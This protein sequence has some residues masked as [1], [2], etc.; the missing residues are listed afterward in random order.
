MS[1]TETENSEG[2]KKLRERAEQAAEL[3]AK[4]AVLERK[5]ALREAGVDLDSEL[6]QEL[7]ANP[8]LDIERWKKIATPAQAEV[9]EDKTNVKDPEAEARK[10][11]ALASVKEGEALTRKVNDGSSTPDI[12]NQGQ[13][14]ADT[15][16]STFQ[17]S[18]KRGAGREK[19]LSSAV[20]VIRE[21]GLKG[22][23][24]AVYSDNDPHANW[25]Q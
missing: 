19:A 6:G 22:D 16:L 10:A 9:K 17:E 25:R 2:I 12:D 5:D 1:D 7:L 3:E 14:P 8:S 4:L 15:A 13:H 21:A 24:R 20:A 11:E 23:Q 18:L